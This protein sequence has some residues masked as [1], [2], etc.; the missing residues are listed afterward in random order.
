MYDFDGL[1]YILKNEEDKWLSY[2]R[3]FPDGIIEA[4]D[5][6]SLRS[7]EEAF[8]YHTIEEDIMF[9]SHLYMEFQ[10]NLGLK[11]P[12]NIHLDLLE[13]EG[14]RIKYRR[15][16]KDFNKSHPIDKKNLS[17]PSILVKGPVD[18]KQVFKGTFG[19]EKAF[20]ISWK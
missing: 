12:F 7:G 17:L 1:V 18:T 11:F 5:A 20:A 2:V 4:V 13:V 10:V 16:T 6:V 9:N 3:I 19:D 8:P 15:D 14:K